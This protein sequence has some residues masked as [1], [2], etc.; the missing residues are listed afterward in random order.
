[1]LLDPSPALG[2]VLIA[3]S[4]IPLLHALFAGVFGRR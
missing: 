4:A 2:T 1:V 3:S